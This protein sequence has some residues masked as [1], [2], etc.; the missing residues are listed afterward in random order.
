MQK[1][2]DHLGQPDLVPYV[3]IVCDTL[4]VGPDHDAKG[5]PQTLATWIVNRW[6]NTARIVDRK[7]PTSDE[8][9]RE[10][11]SGGYK[12][13]RTDHVEHLH[14]AIGMHEFGLLPEGTW[15]LRDESGGARLRDRESFA[16]L[17]AGARQTARDPLRLLKEN[18]VPWGPWLSVEA[19]PIH[20]H[21]HGPTIRHMIVSDGDEPPRAMAQ[22][23]LRFKPG[24]EV[25]V[26][27]R[28]AVDGHVLLIA[29]RHP[30][31]DA[32]VSERFQVLNDFP[33]LACKRS[34]VYRAGE[35]R[36]TKPFT[37][38][39]FNSS[40]TLYIVNWPQ[41]LKPADYGLTG[42]FADGTKEIDS[43]HL[44]NIGLAMERGA[45]IGLADPRAPRVLGGR[46]S[47]IIQDE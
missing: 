30:N 27:F 20:R 45:R 37:L 33:K 47:L 1:N 38:T 8:A 46:Q 16:T 17:V 25:A 29:H 6:G 42:L 28:T 32:D 39:R 41:V 18:V 14:Y 5:G 34:E 9:I 3:K 10:I 13:T 23:G 35:I 31:P 12:Q 21:D 4:R 11:L 24:A 7:I 22:E 44:A 36:T 40:N 15:I 19:Q 26:R 2:P 43:H